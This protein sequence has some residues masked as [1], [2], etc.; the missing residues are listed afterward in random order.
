MRLYKISIWNTHKIYD[1]PKFARERAT[2]RIPRLRSRQSRHLTT[3]LRAISVGTTYAER[4][5]PERL[6]PDRISLVVIL[7]TTKKSWWSRKKFS[8]LLIF[9][10]PSAARCWSQTRRRPVQDSSTTR[11]KRSRLQKFVLRVAL[12]T[13]NPNVLWAVCCVGPVCAVWWDGPTDA[14]VLW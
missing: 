4:P 3:R 12:A 5:L 2:T 9:R 8:A 14:R 7:V 6:E 10:V 1:L 13:L 11:S